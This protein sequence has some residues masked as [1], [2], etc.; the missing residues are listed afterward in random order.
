M[1]KLTYSNGITLAGVGNTARHNLLHDAPHMAVGGGG[2]DNIFEYNI[3]RHVCL[4]AD[5][6][7]AYYKGRNPARRGNIVRYNFWHSIGKP[8]GHG[9]AA[10]YFDDGDG[11]DAVIGNLVLPLV[12]IPARALSARCSTTAGTTS[13]LTT[14]SSLSANGR[15][16]S[17]P[18][19]DKRWRDAM[20][21]K[22]YQDRLTKE[23]D[24]RV[25]PYHHAII[26]R[27]SGILMRSSRSR[28]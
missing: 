10:V 2:N 11:G 25:P 19:N 8:M 3:V 13:W 26:P 5:D 6:S 20:N 21:S 4:A 23:V 9:V 7:G 17:S 1:H 27:W 22:L 16:G 12:A 14:T 18:W 28:G 24:I 15:L